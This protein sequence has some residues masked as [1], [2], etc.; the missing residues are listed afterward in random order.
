MKWPK[1]RLKRV[2]LERAL[3]TCSAALVVLLSF[4][5]RDREA[6]P[7][8]ERLEEI[9]AAQAAA[10]AGMKDMQHTVV[11][12]EDGEGYLVPVQ[13]EIERQDGIA[14]ATLEMM[15][16]NPRN[17]MDAARMGLMPVVPEGTTFDLDISQGHARVDLGSGALR[18]GDKQQEENMRTAIVWALTEFDTVKDVSF[19]VGGQKRDT[20]T[21]GTNI[22]GSYTRVGL[23]Q[24]EP[25]VPTF[26]GAS[27][28]QV[29]FPSQDG[30]LLVPVSRTVYSQDDV[31]TAVFEFLRGPKE[32]SGLS[33]P[34]DQDVQL[35][36]VSVA[37]GVVTINFTKA[38]TK[39]A[40]QSDGGVQAMRALMMTCTRYPGIRRVRILV[41]G[42]PYQMPLED[43]PTFANMEADAAGA[44]AEVM[45]IE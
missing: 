9:P 16:Q 41:D 18:A 22:S 28:V 37:D 19:L 23:N 40:E 13:R 24:E 35:L 2:D 15:V 10:S 42:E 43:A 17:D 7:Y 44:F 30:R 21:H 14:K 32:D 4:Q 26:S 36:G 6:E 1:I 11:Y 20:L 27:E 12:Y 33:A 25:A 29:Y 38:F 45:L 31:A 8:E 39:I 5:S 34:L 3:I